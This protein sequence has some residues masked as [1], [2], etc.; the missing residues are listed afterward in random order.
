M[1]GNTTNMTIRL[2]TNLKNEADSFFR[3]MGLSTS[4]AIN[5]FLRQTLREGK[6]PFTIG[7]PGFN[8]ETIEAFQEAERIAKDPNVKGYTDLDEAWEELKR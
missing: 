6:I 8:Q 5:I 3:E 2:D 1:A 4:T 7:W